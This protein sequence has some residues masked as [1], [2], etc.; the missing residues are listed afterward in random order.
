[1]NEQPPTKPIQPARISN[2]ELALIGTAAWLGW[3]LTAADAGA[4]SFALP[5]MLSY[6]H[7]TVLQFGIITDIFLVVA[8]IYIAF[9]NGPLIERFGR[10]FM[11]NVLF[12][13]AAVFS[14]LS[15]LSINVP[16]LVVFRAL[17][18]AMNGGEQTA[19]QTLMAEFAPAKRRG[20]FIGM[21][22]TGYQLGYVIASGLALLIL[23]RFPLDVG[24]RYLFFALGIPF[25][26]VAA[27]RRMV[28]ETPRF[29][30]L[31]QIR[32]ATKRRDFNE[33][34]RLKQIYLVDEEKAIRFPIR[35]LFSKDLLRSTVVLSVYTFI[36][37][38]EFAFTTFIVL[39]LTQVKGFTNTQADS[40]VFFALMIAAVGYVFTGFIGDKI[41]R[42]EMALID[43]AMAAI[44]AVMF[45]IAPP[46]NYRL[47]ITV[48]GLL[49]FFGFGVWAA[50]LGLFT[51]SFPTRARGTGAAFT[52]S[53][54]WSGGIFWIF[55][56]AFLESIYGFNT[57]Y[58]VVLIGGNF[59][60][61]FALL[62]LK[63]IPPRQELESIKY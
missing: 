9:L 50:N 33:V 27:Y 49:G 61:F 19:S 26:L 30:V 10:R 17:T 57:A 39:Y 25:V 21:V 55:L 48:Y 6:F 1:L 22:Q 11:F 35:Q 46:S 20:S 63:R 44:M 18:L 60:A 42:R 29:T 12:V 52:N 3:T 23:P 8:W 53:M 40:I 16:M 54:Y 13:G 58:K 45:V 38:W 34:Q 5:G 4:I 7:L 28:P 32:E 14:V 37:A 51:E 24:W 43:L 15:G 47:M 56:L 62:A 36:K 31:K 59:L 41:G 2:R